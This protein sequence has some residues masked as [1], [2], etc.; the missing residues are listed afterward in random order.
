M[1]LRPLGLGVSGLADVLA[2]PDLGLLPDEDIIED[3]GRWKIQWEFDRLVKEAAQAF[4]EGYE[5]KL[6]ERQGPGAHT[7]ADILTEAG[8]KLAYDLEALDRLVAFALR[9]DPWIQ[10]T[11][12]KADVTGLP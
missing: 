2:L 8:Q 12:F 1:Q 4:R 3:A 5:P 10:D 9:Q 6:P 11:V 7:R